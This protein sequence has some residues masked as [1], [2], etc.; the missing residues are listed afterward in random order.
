MIA[1]VT[2]ATTRRGAEN[3]AWDL[4]FG[5]VG[6][7]WRCWGVS[8]TSWATRSRPSSD[9]WIGSWSQVRTVSSA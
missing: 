8:W 5:K 4:R 9:S 1:M 7:Q 6:H 3:M 2:P